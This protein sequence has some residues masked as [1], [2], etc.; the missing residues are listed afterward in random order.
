MRA[1]GDEGQP[2]GVT[3]GLNTLRP[4]RH[5]RDTCLLKSAGKAAHAHPH[6]AAHS[7]GVLDD[8]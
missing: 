7:D 6:K 3:S 2:A 8:Q 5:C 4:D 1:I